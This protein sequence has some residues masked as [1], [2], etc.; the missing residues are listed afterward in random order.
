[1][2]TR[3][4]SSERV[5]TFSILQRYTALFY[6][7]VVC[8]LHTSISDPGILVVFEVVAGVDATSQGNPGGEITCGWGFLRLFKSDVKSVDLSDAAAA[9]AK[10]YLH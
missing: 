1:M 9:A 2:E 7:F 6:L 10:R 4:V 8:L 3:Q 5:N